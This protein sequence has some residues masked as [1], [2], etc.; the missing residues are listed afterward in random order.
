MTVRLTKPETAVVWRSTDL[1]RK[2]TVIPAA[3]TC[4][5][6]ELVVKTTENNGDFH[7]IFPNSGT[8]G[9]LP[10]LGMRDSGGSAH[11][12][13]DGA[14]ND[15]VVVCLCTNP[16]QKSYRIKWWDRVDAGQDAST[17]PPPGP[18]ASSLTTATLTIRL[19]TVDFGI[20]N[21][22]TPTRLLC[23]IYTEGL[24]PAGS[25]APTVTGVSDTQGLTWHQ[26]SAYTASLF[27]TDLGGNQGI[28]F[29]TWWADCSGLA[30]GT[31]LQVT[32]VFS[33]SAFVPHVTVWSLQN[34]G[35][36]DADPGL[37]ASQISTAG[38]SLPSFPVATQGDQSTVFICYVT[39]DRAYKP[40]GADAVQLYPNPVFSGL[41]PA[42][43][44]LFFNLNQYMIFTIDLNSAGDIAA[45]GNTGPP[46]DFPS[47]NPPLW[48]VYGGGQGIL[49]TSIFVTDASRLHIFACTKTG[50]TGSVEPI[51]DTSAVGASTV[52]HTVT[53][54]Y[55][56]TSFYVAPFYTRPPSWTEPTIGGSHFVNRGTVITDSARSSVFGLFTTGV[57]GLTEPAWNTSGI[58]ATTMDGTA[59]WV[60]SNPYTGFVG[61]SGGGTDLLVVID[62]ID[63]I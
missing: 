59:V 1:G 4:N 61:D 31:T 57:T 33:S 30:A 5:G 3:N 21:F 41:F 6:Y 13:A 24:P 12:L 15:W 38:S 58:G 51:W 25:T 8:I 10:S 23:F 43:G 62:A 14:N 49:S 32:A 27:S 45:A 26:R 54:E 16:L 11:L 46:L 2:T 34:A 63:R 56:G 50:N 39:P 60:Y 29:E 48:R 37:P 35:D 7:T 44:G 55:V 9:G 42:L 52:D 17:D 28:N 20:G 40:L 53:W 19:N 22:K 18:I 36:F 47:N